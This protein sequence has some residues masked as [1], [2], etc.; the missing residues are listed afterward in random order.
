MWVW[1]LFFWYNRS[2]F[3]GFDSSL[4]GNVS[5][6][7]DLIIGGRL[8]VK[9]FTSQNI[10]NT[11]T[12]N[13]QLIVSEDL[14]LNGRMF[15][16]GNVM[17]GSGNEP[18]YTLDVS[19]ASTQPFR[20]GVGSNNA[21]VVDN[22]GEVGIG[23]TN[24]AVELDVSGNM[25][26][27]GSVELRGNV[28]MAPS[29]TSSTTVTPNVSGA[30]SA[31]Y[32]TATNSTRTWVNNDVIWSAKTS[33]GV[34]INGSDTRAP[35][36]AFDANTS[37]G[38][39]QVG[40]NNSTSLFLY[41]NTTPFLYA[42]SVSTTLQNNV[43]STAGEWL[44]INSSRLIN[45]KDYAI[46]SAVANRT[47]K[48]YFIAG[49]VDEFTWEPIIKIDMAYPSGAPSRG[50]SSGTITIPSGTETSAKTGLTYNYTYTT[51]GNGTKSY[52][53]FRII[54][55]NLTGT[56]ASARVP[57]LDEWN[58]N[59][60]LPV[61][62]L[63]LSS[64][65]S[66]TNNMVLNIGENVVMAPTT[67]STTV[68]PNTNSIENTTTP[69]SSGITYNTSTN[70]TNTWVNGN[71]TWYAKVST[72]SFIS[73][74]D[75]RTPDHM[76]N[77]NKGT[78]A[79]A[80]YNGWMLGNNTNTLNS[81]AAATG[82]GTTSP[83][84]YT[85]TAVST[86][87]E[88]GVG[89][90]GGQWVQLVSNKL[91]S[92]TEYEIFIGPS[93][94]TPKIYFIAGSTDEVTWYPIIKVEMNGLPNNNDSSTNQGQSCGTITIPS[95]T[96]TSVTTTGLT[97]NYTYTT[98][99]N[100]RNNYKY[101]RMIIT[102]VNNSA[103]PTINEWRIN[104][105]LPNDILSLRSNNDNNIIVNVD[106]KVG[107]GTIDPK[108]QLH[109]FGNDNTNNTSKTGSERNGM[110]TTCIASDANF[111][112]VFANYNN[113][114]VQGPAVSGTNIF[115]YIKDSTGDKRKATINTSA[116]TFTGQHFVVPNDP[117]IK[118]NLTEYV[119]LI[120]SSNNTGYT[121]YYN[122]V[123]YTGIDAI[124]ICEAL[125][126][127]KLSTIDNDKAVFG[128]I[129]NQ[130]NE[131]YFGT[132]GQPL[133]DNTDDGFER[134]LY[135]RVR[136]NSIGEGSI[137]VTNINGNIENGDYITS[138]I[139]PGYGKRQNDDLLHNYTVGKSTMSCDFDINS[140]RYKTK[141]IDFNGN[142]YIAAFIGCT[143]HCG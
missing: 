22:L 10:I 81:N 54:I 104:F 111:T 70:T 105:N 107:I 84:N 73:G 5:I 121:S 125:P 112:E 55:T 7:N 57:H 69:S 13:Y 128:V 56:D 140:T 77:S 133:Y 80:T 30:G 41:N 130:E 116:Y 12:N 21:I 2:L 79:N 18:Y 91:I 136:V 143:Y 134:D 26:V 46:Y 67:S 14:S 142:S 94:R 52:K 50:T 32:D 63:T 110:L 27:S 114:T 71:V 96:A 101:F 117:E 64:N 76:F 122:K 78:G 1:W 123:K 138:S 19:S 62:T 90:I 92:M 88:N 15:V 34:L 141:T 126:N 44:Q 36:K 60:N 139:I 6:R 119:G 137:W 31:T 124:R 37:G 24:P 40:S 38:E 106:G 131:K 113:F 47:P 23:K 65:K 74:A 82:Y 120:V 72:G 25:N 3:V 48:I 43:G 53:Y 132:D 83:Y 129:T 42:G 59:F 17:I 9:N 16:K 115:F 99:G 28:R 127:C 108:A 135:D 95:G 100:G 89:S 20:V 35:S 49:S 85:G 39:W 45:M 98:Y 75:Q 86:T 102:Q 97:Y 33:T 8:N 51:Y 11:T 58:I 87:L 118:T 4:N 93:S 68:T 29:F 103:Y 61:D 66:T 109:I